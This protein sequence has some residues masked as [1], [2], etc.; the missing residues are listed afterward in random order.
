MTGSSPAVGSSVIGQRRSTA[1]RSS[2]VQEKCSPRISSSWPLVRPIPSR[3]RPTPIAPTTPRTMCVPR[4]RPWPSQTMSLLL[5]AGPVGVELAG[6]IHAAW[7]DKAVTIVDVADDVLGGRFSGELRAELR[8]QLDR[9]QRR[10]GPRNALRE[11][12]PPRSR[13]S[14]ATSASEPSQAGRSR[15]ISGSVASASRR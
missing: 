12:E 6:E 8:R 15:L 1:P 7:P 11:G 3:P 13:A 5:G 4:T 9:D 10:V 14:W 2:S